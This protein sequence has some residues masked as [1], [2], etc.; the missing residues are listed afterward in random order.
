MHTDTPKW[1]FEGFSV[2]HPENR[3]SMNTHY[4]VNTT[5]PHH[6]YM[7]TEQRR[8]KLKSARTTDELYKTR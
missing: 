3:I 1:S 4:R 6:G 7:I 5:D 8:L 2:S